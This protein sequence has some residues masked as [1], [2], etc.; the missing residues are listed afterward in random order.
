MFQNFYWKIM[1][2]LLSQ[3]F[4]FSVAICFL[5]QSQPAFP[6]GLRPEASTWVLKILS[7]SQDNLGRAAPGTIQ[8]ARETLVRSYKSRFSPTGIRLTIS[9]EIR[10]GMFCI[11]W[12]SDILV[13]KLSMSLFQMKDSINSSFLLFCV[14]FNLSFV[15]SSFKLISSSSGAVEPFCLSCNLDWNQNEKYVKKSSIKKHFVT[16][17]TDLNVTLKHTL[18]LQ[19]RNGTTR[20]QDNVVIR[21]EHLFLI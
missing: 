11:I 6:H 10:T 20:Q 17:F 19:Y 18:L 5:G 16:Y 1:P 15:V 8:V 9:A 2:I 12:L 7:W 21:F 13:F 14:N 3:I 4:H